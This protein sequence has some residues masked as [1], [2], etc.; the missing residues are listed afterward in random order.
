MDKNHVM[1]NIRNFL[2]ANIAGDDRPGV[3]GGQRQAELRP[4]HRVQDRGNCELLIMLEY[5][6]ISR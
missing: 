1:E 4:H 5:S 2:D 6:A 3:D